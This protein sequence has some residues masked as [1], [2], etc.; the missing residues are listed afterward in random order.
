[1]GESLYKKPLII[2]V[3]V[4]ASQNAPAYDTTR[5]DPNLGWNAGAVS[6]PILT[7]DGQANFKSTLGSTGVVVGF[8]DAPNSGLADYFDL[9]FGIYFSRAKFQII[10]LG[11]VKTIKQS[12][13]ATD[14][15]RIERT[16]SVIKY[17][18]NSTLVY[19][20]SAS[21]TGP[22][23]LNASLYAAGD[24]VI[25]ANLI[26]TVVTNP[27]GTVDPGIV[28][29]QPL[30]EPVVQGIYA[31]FAPMSA[32]LN[33]R[34]GRTS[35]IRASFKPLSAKLGNVVLSNFNAELMGF[36]TD[37]A[38]T[39][40][41][42]D[43]FKATLSGMA[44][45][46]E[47]TLGAEVSLA[48]F[49]TTL[50][51][52]LNYVPGFNIELAGFATELTGT[53]ASRPQFTIDLE[54]FATSVDGIMVDDS[55][56]AGHLAGFATELEATLVGFSIA[57]IELAGFATD[58]RADLT[59]LPVFKAELAG[60]ATEIE[61]SAGMTGEFAGLAM[62]LESS[63][64]D[65]N[66]HNQAFVMNV[67]TQQVSR[68]TNQ[69]FI[70]LLTVGNH[71]FGVRADGLYRLDKALLTDRFEMLNDSG[72]PVT[73]ETP[74]N[75]TVVTK[76]TDFGVFQAKRVPYCYLD[77]DTQ[78]QITPLVDSVAKLPHLSSFN[79][80]KTHLARGPSGRYWQFK[81]EKI[82]KVEGAEF[83][84]EQ[85]QRRVK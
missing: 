28:I 59:V 65:L 81:L 37:L 77:S 70:A 11:N 45:S 63:S 56:Y 16:G 32:D 24:A 38:G 54:G 69:S 50:T 58:I 2:I 39:M 53:I 7:A 85:R 82:V 84:P 21:S 34:R 3:H 5:L 36:A 15:F 23:I 57:T 19:Q 72:T 9:P 12:F 64:L 20:S 46:L 51:A 71:L 1:M 79:G 26:T 47:A 18:R 43:G 60:F 6:L 29:N 10:E 44:T 83:L 74:I 27:T 8:N 75:G 17:Y 73:V 22:V 4:P 40:V 30:T 33:A 52:E 78:T 41:E 76:D 13:L 67:T 31:G 25:D 66:Q 61:G 68:Y 49:A 48:G 62:V 42:A 14:V 35:Q 55:A 80:R